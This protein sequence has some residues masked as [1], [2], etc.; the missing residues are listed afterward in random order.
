MSN[1][2]TIKE[3]GRVMTAVKPHHLLTYELGQ[4]CEVY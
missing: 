1:V 2:I 3:D 4:V